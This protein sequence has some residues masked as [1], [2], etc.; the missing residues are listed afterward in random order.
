MTIRSQPRSLAVAMI[1]LIGVI[2]LNLKGVASH[3]AIL[4]HDRNVAQNLGGMLFD[5]LGVLR[6]S[7]RHALDSGFRHAV[8]AE[9]SLHD[10]RSHFGADPFGKFQAM[11]H[12]LFGKG[13]AIGCN[14]NILVHRCL[15]ISVKRRPSPPAF[16][17][18]APEVCRTGHP[19]RAPGDIDQSSNTVDPRTPRNSRRRI[20]APRHESF[21]GS[22]WAKEAE[23]GS[24]LQW[25][26]FD[27]PRQRQSRP[28]SA[29]TP[30]ADER[31]HGWNGR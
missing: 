3:A 23:A 17:A 9:G 26:I 4:G 19:P 13:S 8:E 1:G 2:V 27:R 16:V 14:Q 25:V 31:G 21:D 15:L 28:M 22:G 6:Q 12:R 18:S 20:C 24:C 7:F 30:I 10:Q 29:V 5:V 11:L